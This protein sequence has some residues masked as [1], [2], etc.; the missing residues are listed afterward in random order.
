MTGRALRLAGGGAALFVLGWLGVPICPMAAVTGHPCPG[1]GLTRATLALLHGHLREAVALHPVAPLIVPL[2]GGFVAY[3][4]V[5]YVRLGR[6]PATS[7][8][9]AA[10]M[11]VV[12]VALWALLLGVWLA[13]FMGAF[14]GPVAV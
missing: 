7:G 9:A 3:G 11:A 12:G 10:R 6:W 14:G 13:R 4:A 8:P 2:L 5:Q 1:C